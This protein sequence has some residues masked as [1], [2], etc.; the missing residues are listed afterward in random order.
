M[1]L[2]LVDSATC[3]KLRY[4]AKY[5][6]ADSGA[7]DG[8]GVSLHGVTRVTAHDGEVDFYRCISGL[9]SQNFPVYAKVKEPLPLSRLLLVLPVPGAT[10]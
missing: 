10:H 4:Y 1:P 3:R 8:T 7:P 5:A 9:L 2:E 6:T